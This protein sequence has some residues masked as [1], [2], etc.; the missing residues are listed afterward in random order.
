MTDSG[1]LPDPTA[2]LDGAPDPA[3][4]LGVQESPVG[5]EPA[6]E[7]ASALRIALRVGLTLAAIAIAGVVLAQAF[8]DLDP[9]E[10]AAALG[11]LSDAAWLALISGWLTWVGAQGLQTASLVTDLPARRGVVAW[12]GPNAVASVI[13]GPSDLPVRYAMYRS[14]RVEPIDAG[15]AVAMSGIFSIGS[16]LVLPA[17]AGV[18]I[19]LG[20]A[21][22]DG[23][24]TIIAATTLVLAAALVVIAV[25][26]GS[27]RRTARAG[28]LLD[29]VWRGAARVLRRADPERSL[30]PILVEQRARAIAYLNDKWVTTTLATALTVVAKWSLLVMSLRFVGVTE[31][32]IGTDEVFVV[33]ALVAG[34]TVVPITPGSAGVTEVALV[35]MLTSIG[36]ASV[37]DIAAGTLLYRLLTWLVPI[38]VGFAVLARWRVA[39]RRESGSATGPIEP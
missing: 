36:D 11:D 38:P 3:S 8:D 25:V 32:E 17:L 19:V 30:G 26:L 14:W 27:D 29:P 28:A 12:L 37:N 10:I 21:T 31:A 20:A 22:I 1:E 2:P 33:Y 16:Q 9:A 35:A 15:T 24:G 18:S 4:N 5:D 7:R 13:P 39:S 34:L 6:D 23:V